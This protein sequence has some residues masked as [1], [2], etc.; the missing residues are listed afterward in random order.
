MI[1]SMA[2]QKATNTA[3]IPCALPNKSPIAIMSFTSP[4]PN[5]R[6]REYSHIK[7]KGPATRGIATR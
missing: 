2:I 7:K 1:Q 3:S 6:P 5:Q 4:N